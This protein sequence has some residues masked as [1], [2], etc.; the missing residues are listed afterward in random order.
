MCSLLQV[1][2]SS[3]LSRARKRKECRGLNSTLVL[4]YAL[5]IVFFPISLFFTL[6][7]PPDPLP[8]G[9]CL[10]KEME[11]GLSFPPFAFPLIIQVSQGRGQR[12]AGWGEDPGEEQNRGETKAQK[13]KSLRGCLTY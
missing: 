9:P 8:T 3:L 6:N 5:E 12:E 4:P 7:F 1:T 11:K 10:Q 2:P 13:P